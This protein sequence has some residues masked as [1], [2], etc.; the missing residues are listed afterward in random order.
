MLCSQCLEKEEGR[1]GGSGK[2]LPSLFLAFDFFCVTTI[3]G[4]LV[5][6][7]AVDLLGH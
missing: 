6:C 7:P 1:E 4:V 2:A 5:Q 3:H